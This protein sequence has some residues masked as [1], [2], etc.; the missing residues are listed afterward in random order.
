MDYLLSDGLGISIAVLASIGAGLIR[1][2]TGFGSSLVLAP[3]L[4]Q[5]FGP[6]EAV[7]ISLVM[8]VIASLQMARIS[9]SEIDRQQVSIVAGA[10]LV[11]L[12][13]GMFLLYHLH[14]EFMRRSIGFATIAAATMIAVAP[15]FKIPT[16]ILPPV[17]AGSFGGLIMG[18]T[19]MGG[20][21]I[22]L[23]FISRN[24]TSIQKKANIVFSVGMLE[25]AAL[26]VF[27]FYGFININ[28]ITIISIIAPF[29]MIST[30][31]GFRLFNL[32][33]VIFNY[34]VIAVAILSGMSAILA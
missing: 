22:V 33:G 21:P 10:G 14:P 25:I 13:P 9:G 27:I 24:D 3:V 32:S 26:L 16:G 5:L 2:V 6:V 7:G 29:F 19:S 1:G 18:A 11:A 34:F 17:V 31:I 8:G 20:P 23:Y 12:I 30:F 4:A 15:Q 28:T